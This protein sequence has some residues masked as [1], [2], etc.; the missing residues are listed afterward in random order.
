M[1]ST[2]S[3]RIFKYIFHPLP[4]CVT[5]DDC[6][7]KGRQKVH[8]Q[9]K[10][11]TVI[12]LAHRCAFLIL[13]SC[14]FLRVGSLRTH[15]SECVPSHSF[16]SRNGHVAR[17]QLESNL[18]ATESPQLSHRSPCFVLCLRWF[19]KVGTFRALRSECVPSH[20][21]RSLSLP[22]TCYMITVEK[23]KSEEIFVQ[24]ILF[25]YLCSIIQSNRKGKTLINYDTGNQNRRWRAG[26]RS[27]KKCVSASV[28]CRR[29]T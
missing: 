12:Q 19:L 29:G 1:R 28:R 17:R 15:R 18:K 13:C 24:I 20:S 11:I 2:N 25:L 9:K 4:Y 21:F 5:G 3:I 22:V 14:L 16:R 10:A 8:H 23:T 27:A 7:Q 26:E 6:L